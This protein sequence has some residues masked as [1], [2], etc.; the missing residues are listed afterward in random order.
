MSRYRPYNYDENLIRENSRKRK[1][2]KQLFFSDEELSLIQN[3]MSKLNIDNFSY[4]MRAVSCY[5]CNIQKEQIKNIKQDLD[6]KRKNR[7]QLCFSNEELLLIQDNMARL[8]IINFSFYMRLVGCYSN[9][10]IDEIKNV[11]LRI[12]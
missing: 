9:T 1:N 12:M 4:Y 8:N 6:K 3:N 10:T 7:K 11:E 5:C 2:R